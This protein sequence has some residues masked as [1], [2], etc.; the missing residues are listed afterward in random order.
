MKWSEEDIKA[1]WEHGLKV[2]GVDSSMFR[3]DACGAWIAFDDYGQD[4]IFAWE[5]DHIC[6][7]S[8]LE[9]KHI[10]M[11]AINDIRNLR[12]LHHA[13]NASKGND[14]PS[15]TAVITA[16]EGRNIEEEKNL[17][18]NQNKYQEL[19]QLFNL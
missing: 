5:V 17:T 10:S 19:K 16:E 11:D 18:I 13:N 7:V 12:P 4:T 8:L 6:P 3:K 15:Y 9:A 1:V 2:D 14:F